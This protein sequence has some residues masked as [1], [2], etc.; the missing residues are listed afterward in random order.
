[1]TNL[2]TA[3]KCPLFQGFRVITQ[4][5]SRYSEISKRQ[6]QADAQ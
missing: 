3:D 2:E 5:D 4:C 6:Q 1:M